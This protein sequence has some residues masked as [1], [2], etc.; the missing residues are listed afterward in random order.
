MRVVT[1]DTETNSTRAAC[2]LRN[3]F[4][5]NAK[6]R[7]C[8]VFR[9]CFSV[10]ERFVFLHMV[11]FMSP[12]APPFVYIL[13]DLV[14]SPGQKAAAH[15]DPSKTPVDTGRVRRPEDPEE[16]VLPRVPEC[17][18]HCQVSLAW[19]HSTSPRKTATADPDCSK[20]RVAPEAS[21][22]AANEGTGP[23]GQGPA[24]SA[25]LSQALPASQEERQAVS[26]NHSKALQTTG[27]LGPANPQEPAVLQ[28]SGSGAERAPRASP[29]LLSPPEAACGGVS[30]HCCPRER[31]G[32][33]VTDVDRLIK[34]LGASEAGLQL[35]H[36][37]DR[38]S[39]EGSPQG[40]VPTGAGGGS[41]RR[42]EPVS[43]DQTP[44]QRRAWAAGA[45]PLSQWASQPSV[46]DS[47]H[48]DKHF[49]VNKNFLSNYSRN[50][51]SFHEDSTSLSGPGDSTE[52]SLSSMYGDAED[53]SS[54]PE[55]LAEALRAST[56][57][58]WS[59]PRSRGSSHKEDTTESEEE[60]VEICSTG[61]PPSPPTPAQAAPRPAAARAVPLKH[62][63]RREA[64]ASLCDSASI[65]PA[66][67]RPLVPNPAQPC[68]LMDVSP[69]GRE[70]HAG[71][72]VTQDHRRSWEEAADAASTRSAVENSRPPRVAG[73]FPGPPVT[74]SAPNVANGSERASS[75][76]ETTDDKQETENRS[77][78]SVGVPQNG[79]PVLADLHISESQDQDD[80]LQK[81]KMISRRPIMAW[82]KEINK[83]NPGAHVQSKTEKEQSMLPAKSPDSKSQVLGT[84]H[85][86]GVAVPNSPPQLKLNLENK[87]PPKKSS[88]ETLLS[89]C[90]KPK[91]G[92][93]LKRLSIRSKSKGSSEAPAASAP[94]AGGTDHRKSLLTLQTSH[95][96]LPKVASHRFHVADH[97]DPDKNATATAKSP[98]GVL[99]SKPPP[100]ASGSLRPSAS[101]T[102][103]RPF[104]PPLTSPK[105]LPEQGA[106]SRF[107]TALPSEPSRGCPAT[108][109]SPQCGPDIKVPP[110]APGTGP[111]ALRN[112]VCTAV[113][114]RELPL[115]GQGQQ[116]AV[117]QTDWVPEAAPPEVTGNK[118]SRT[119]TNDPLERT[120]QLKI[121]EIPSERMPKNAS[122]DKPAESDRQGGFL[123][124]SNCQ[125]S[126]IR[127]CHQSVESSPNHPSALPSFA[128]QVEQEM[129]R[130]FR[131]A[132]LSSSSSSPQLLA[133]KADSSP[134]KSSQMSDCP[135]TPKNSTT[136]GPALDDH[137]YFTPRPA[138][139]TYSMPAEFSSHFG[140]EGPS[141]HSPGRTQRDSQ[142]P[143]TSG[144]LLE[145]KAARG[146]VPGLINGQGVY[147]VKSLLET[148][149]NLPTTDEGDV[150][151]LQETSCLITDK[152]RVTRR[153]YYSEQNW[154]HESTSFFSVK[155]RIKSFENLANADRPAAKSGASPFLSVSSKPPIGRRSSGS[156]AS[157]SLS[158][159]GDPMARS[160]RRSLSSCSESQS[161][162]ST[163]IP[164]M[165]KSPSST[166]LTISRQN[167]V[168]SSSNKGPD[169]D[170]KKSLGP[171][172][173]PTPAVIPASPI[174]RNKSSARHAQPS[175]LSR[176]KLQELRALSMPDLDKLC[177][178]DFSAEPTA[179]LF[180]TELEIVP[181]RSRGSPAGG[182]SGST[183]PSCPIKQGN[184]ACPERSRLKASEPRAPSSASDVGETTQDLPP[185]KSW[186]VK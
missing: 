90:Q 145:V 86:K 108:P 77:S 177:G 123:A 59:P 3:V 183:A 7:V 151:S 104:T 62:G 130:S 161:E 116:R 169:S 173:I 125:K 157:G 64:G 140:R 47:I 23:A 5:K 160:L 69:H 139:R 148:A 135:G 127:L 137:P 174:K 175:P 84:S 170:P 111:T 16:P 67:P 32:S 92:P 182:L 171:S 41:P 119:I 87:D 149:R 112:C 24:A 124:Q 38:T 167:L 98:Q 138:T 117:S 164:Q 134:G 96:M 89:S 55:S 19:E 51:S 37:G 146:G 132:K 74:L 54:D 103:I 36:K 22:P 131:M 152:I 48:P 12:S 126:E 121:V 142:I 57:D 76:G 181:R 13:P 94:K 2:G 66:A 63:A 106:N 58:N 97:E 109:R 46:L 102:S 147:S 105:T 43:G 25:V 50:L 88:V 31:G 21:L 99:E 156:V 52:P 165:T 115:P 178:E 166:M 30:G 60:Q 49:T 70:P 45:A 27:T 150:L 153:H 162:A 95:K 40:P 80:L 143:S 186:S 114:K 133:K 61:G 20:P 172:G 82:F 10:V 118:G 113:D 136:A 163:L 85:R 44:T 8:L 18:D 33:P 141:L 15:P 107:H 100:A 26:G 176:S 11:P 56:K 168:E 78:C 75:D 71:P 28:G 42:A 4:L 65:A 17:E 39:Q 122:G 91:A 159:S 158:H 53:S 154:P 128:S 14:P 93:K 83:S 34:D 81:P 184:R 185:R 120:N 9:S 179:V 6:S 155:Q 180:K 1:L 79:D 73:Q 68:S 144:G 129:Q 101:D 110:V 29:A 72:S 35:P